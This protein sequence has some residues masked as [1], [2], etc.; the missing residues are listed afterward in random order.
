MSITE[1]QYPHS[2]DAEQ[3][4]LGSILIDPDALYEVGELLDATSFYRP[5]HQWLYDAVDKL[6]ARQEPPDILAITEELRRAGK[7]DEFG[8]M[9]Y[10]LTLANS[11]PTSVNAAVYAGIVAETATRRRLINASGKIAKAAYNETLPVDEVVAMAE[12]EILAQDTAAGKST[13]RSP[14]RYMSD[15]IDAFLQD[16]ATESP[17]RAVNTGLIDLD[18]TLNGLERSQQYMIAGRTSMGK[19]S[20]AL[21]VAL[22]AG[23]RQG[24]RVLIFSI[25]MSEEQLNNRLISILT[26]IPVNKLRKQVRHLLTAQEQALVM[27][28][29]GQISDSKIF[30][31]TSA[32]LRPSDVRSRAARIYAEH[33]LDMLICD[34]LHIMRP[35]VET[36]NNVKDLGTIAM[37]LAHIYK[38]FDVVGL[39]L[40]QLNRKTDDRAVKQP[41]LS[42]LRESGQIEENA[43]AVLFVHR[44]GYYD[45]TEQENLAQIVIAKNR[46]GAT[47]VVDVYWNPQ[48]ATFK[49][50]VKE[51]IILNSVK[52]NGHSNGVYSR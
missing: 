5:A 51:Q 23:L 50:L 13:V 25:E 31:D 29:A 20:F 19:T 32:S 34:H 38:Q 37:D 45:K 7:L 3:A 40:A 35:N 27:N 44:P 21:G 33:G 15:Y 30:M 22:D 1:L 39:T 49:N 10:L 47:G 26:L 43:Y 6:H 16:V 2:D 4:V 42:D 12:A 36:G 41:M 46:D 18:R 24:K 8:G 17:S 28:A 9:D 14:R 11:V 48:L 52:T